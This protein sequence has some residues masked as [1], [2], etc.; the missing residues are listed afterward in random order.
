MARG[1][2]LDVLRVTV[3]QRCEILEGNPQELLDARQIIGETT[4][5][6]KPDWRRILREDLV[7]G[8]EVFGVLEPGA[9]SISLDYCESRQ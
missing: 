9:W 1:V 5:S 2:Q 3:L 4:G 7:E 8:S 6:R